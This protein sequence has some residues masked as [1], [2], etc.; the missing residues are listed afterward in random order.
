[1]AA[2]KRERPVLD[3]LQVLCLG[4]LLLTVP[5]VF[6]RLAARWYPALYGPDAGSQHHDAARVL[7]RKFWKSA[8]MVFAVVA[9]VVFFQHLRKGEL[10]FA[11]DAWLRI[12]AVTLALMAALGRG[13]WGI[14]S[15]KGTT[16]VERIDRALYTTEQLG[17]AALLI[18][19]LTL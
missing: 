11:G 18:F 12:A 9:L 6:Q 14:Q 1:V 4:F 8:V 17:A 15:F 5:P 16:P 3:R 10:L 2:E 7:R 19:A 13:G